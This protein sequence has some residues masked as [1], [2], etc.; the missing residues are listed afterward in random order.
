MLFRS[1]KINTIEIINKKRKEFFDFVKE[2]NNEKYDYSNFEYITATTKSEIKCNDCNEIFQQSPDAHKQGHGCPKCSGNV[3]LTLEEFIRRSELTHGKDTYDF[4]SVNYIN[5]QTKVSLK[6]NKCNQISMI[7]PQPFWEGQGCHFCGKRYSL[8][9]MKVKKFLESKNINFTQQ[10][11]FKK[12]VYK[13]KLPFDFYLQDYNVCIEY[14]GAQHF[15]SVERWGG[16]NNFEEIKI[17]DNI[18]SDFCKK[19]KIPL[20]RI[21]YNDEKIEERIMGCI[22]NFKNSCQHLLQNEYSNIYL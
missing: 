21:P 20:I 5:N 19:N 4:S 16:V 9:E 3:K 7:Y 13:N 2:N 17:K 14:D 18:K 22:D 11:R 12:C 1:R 15:V 8:G 10:K 6:C